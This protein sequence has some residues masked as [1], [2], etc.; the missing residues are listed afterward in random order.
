MVAFDASSMIHA[1]DNYPLENF[2]PLWDW[3]SNEISSQRIVLSQIAFEEVERKSPD[4]G[5]WLR[6]YAIQRIQISN[7]I[8]AEASRIKSLLGIIDDNY[9][10]KGAGENDILIISTSKVHNLK[11]FTEE[12]QQFILPDNMSNY[13]IPAVCWLSSVNVECDNFTNFIKDSGQVFG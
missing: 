11:L 12:R 7:D 10:A 9:H 6:D 5:R 13:K 1:W 8:L 3:L 4:C 2:P